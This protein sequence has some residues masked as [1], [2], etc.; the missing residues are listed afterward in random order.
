[1]TKKDELSQH[2]IDLQNEIKYQ[3]QELQYMADFLSWKDLWD[4]FVQFRVNAHLEQDESE[5]FPHYVL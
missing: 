3:A 2:V 4:E 1:M 5:P